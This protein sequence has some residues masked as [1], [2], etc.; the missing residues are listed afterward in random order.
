MHEII[1]TENHRL[2][3]RSTCQNLTIISTG[4]RVKACRLLIGAISRTEA[5]VAG[6]QQ[7]RN[8]ATVLRALQDNLALWAPVL[9]EDGM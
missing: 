2:L 1:G 9:T 7:H 6:L 3:L 4:E 5:D 8:S